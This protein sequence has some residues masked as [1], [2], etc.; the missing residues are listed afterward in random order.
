[1]HDVIEYLVEHAVRAGIYV[2]VVLM[3]FVL[4]FGLFRFDP[5]NDFPSVPRDKWQ[6]VFLENGQ[7]YFGRLREDGKEY[8]ILREVYY[9]REAQ[10]AEE[11]ANL[12]LVKLGGELHGPEDA[13]YIRKEAILYWE[14]LKE[15]SRIVDAI[16]KAKQQ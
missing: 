9:L 8:V 2:V 12:N 11:S 7:T 5:W 13:L 3:V 15:T 6:A 10:S 4:I 1:M 16:S 14:N